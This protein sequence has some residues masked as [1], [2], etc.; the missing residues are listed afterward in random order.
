[1]NMFLGKAIPSYD[2]QTMCNYMQNKSL[3]IAELLTVINRAL[4]APNSINGN[5]KV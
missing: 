2:L 1:M 5:I 3:Y 4:I